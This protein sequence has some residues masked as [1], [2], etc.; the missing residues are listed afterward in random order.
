MIGLGA[1]IAEVVPGFSGGTVALVAGIYERL[2][3]NIRGGAHA[4]S[5]LLR[6][7]PSASLR[8]VSTIDWLFIGFLLAGMASALVTVSSGLRAL[9][10]ERSVEMSAMLLGASVLAARRLRQPTPVH[11]LFGTA[12]AAAFFVLL[13]FTSGSVPD[14]TL[15]L[16]F[17]RGSVAICAWIFPGVSCC[18]C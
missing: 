15:V 4:L 1:A 11:A 12:S 9:I 17:A 6:G 3:V 7:K 8:A 10:N 5:L 2:I 14:P 16:V 18:S 13:G